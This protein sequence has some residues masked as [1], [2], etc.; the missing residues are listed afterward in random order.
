[1][2]TVPL[3]RLL[4]S[5]R[6]KHWGFRFLLYPSDA[7]SSDFWLGVH[8]RTFGTSSEVPFYSQGLVDLPDGSS[9]AY[10]AA[11]FYD[12]GH[13]WRDDSGGL[14]REIPHEVLLLVN[15]HE[16]AALSASN[17]S[18]AIMEALRPV[19]AELYPL[20]REE[21]AGG[22]KLNALAAQVVVVG[23]R[24]QADSRSTPQEISVPI[25][26]DTKQPVSPSSGTKTLVALLPV[27]IGLTILLG[28]AATALMLHFNKQPVK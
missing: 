7:K 20:S 13:E 1:M 12:E 14:G 9:V 5:S 6:G 10:L 26:S 28:V 16:R 21:M 22:D 11:R 8:D 4:W 27:V 3:S 15:A 17:W 23:S 25:A 19:Y 2:T 18:H 24:S